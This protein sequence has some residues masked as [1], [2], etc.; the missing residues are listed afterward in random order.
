MTAKLPVYLDCAATTPMEPE[1]LEVIIKY[2]RDEYG[3]SGSRTHEFGAR[4]K[5][6]VERAREQVA[7][8]ANAQPEE[9]IFT[10]GATES[11]NLAILGPEG[12][13]TNERAPAHRNYDDRAQVCTGTN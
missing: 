10:S 4:A 3:N 7:A 9:I 1:V 13:R 2:M 8:V 5:Q 12:R 11:N 6:A